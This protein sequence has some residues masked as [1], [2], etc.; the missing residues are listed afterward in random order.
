MFVAAPV[1]KNG[2]TT[3]PIT[4]AL[5]DYGS[6]IMN[7]TE[8]VPYLA[9]EKDHMISGV[10]ESWMSDSMKFAAFVH[11]YEDKIRKKIASAKTDEDI[12]D[13]RFELEVPYLLLLDERFQVEYEK[14]GVGGIRS[15]DV[16]VVFDQ[17]IEFNMEVKR[18]RESELADRF[19]SL[20]EEMVKEI[21]ETPSPLAFAI[22]MTECD[23]NPDLVDRLESSREAVIK[24]IKQTLLDEQETLSN[25]A[26]RDYPV[27]GFESELTLVLTRPC[28]KMR[29]DETSYHGGAVPI[30]YSGK[31]H[32]KFSDTILDKLGQMIPNM[33]NI[34]VCT[35]DSS[36]HESEDLLA[37]IGSI[38]RLVHEKDEDFFVR[39]GFRDAKD[40]IRQTA[41]LSGVLYRSIWIGQGGYRN[42]LWCNE[43][44]DFQ[45]PEEIKSYL[46]R[47]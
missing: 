20:V 4:E 21:E 15:P 13:V 19:N 33:M 38:N 42:T 27:P 34:I 44:A 35:S 18:I 2:S 31:E 16:S 45:I 10:I 7:P 25:A 46:R 26:A 36:S 12:E 9:G 37:A 22:D 5:S 14:Y 8:T 23:A 30:F 29:T 47:I 43:H 17:H 11:R 6:G 32:Y 24:F 39:R 1:D 28:G 41:R 3:R 40:F